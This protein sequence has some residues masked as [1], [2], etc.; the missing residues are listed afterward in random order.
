MVFN[1]AIRTLLLDADKGEMGIGSGIVY[2]SDAAKEFDE[3]LLKANFLF[4]G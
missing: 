1:V 2:D 4:S 3:C